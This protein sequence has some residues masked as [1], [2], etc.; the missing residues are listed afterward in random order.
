[1]TARPCAGA[2][3]S[4][5]AAAPRRDRIDRAATDHYAEGGLEASL[6][7]CC[8]RASPHMSRPAWLSGSASACQQHSRPSRSR[9]ADPLVLCRIELRPP[10]L[11]LTVYPYLP[12]AGDGGDDLSHVLSRPSRR[13]LV[14]SDTPQLLHTITSRRSSYLRSC[15]NTTSSRS[16]APLRARRGFLVQRVEATEF[17]R[18]PGRHHPI[19]PPEN[20]GIR[21]KSWCDHAFRQRYG[22]PSPAV[23][24]QVR[25]VRPEPALRHYR[26]RV[27]VNRRRLVRR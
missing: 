11:N 17:Q 13:G 9:I 12:R 14:M 18:R 24:E 7:T 27:R 25:K 20:F 6:R 16:N 19:E 8:R 1:V 15:A 5:V 23:W 10:R 2:V 26:R 22:P 3:A 4:A 21:E